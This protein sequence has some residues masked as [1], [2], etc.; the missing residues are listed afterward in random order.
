MSLIN[1][2]LKRAGRVQKETPPPTEPPTA[3]LT[4]VEP[5]PPAPS[6]GRGGPVRAILLMLALASLAG[7]SFF[8]W[9]FF[10]AGSAPPLAAAAKPGP[11][12][13]ADT[14]PQPT[15]ADK[16]ATNLVAEPATPPVGPAATQTV[17]A[18][19]PPPSP[20]AQLEPAGA[21]K[22]PAE[23]ATT[24]VAQAVAPSPAPPPAQATPS[25]PPPA[26]A[27]AQPAAPV[28]EPP[29]VAVAWPPLKLQA[30]IFRVK[31]PKVRINGTNLS[32][33]AEVDGVYVEEIR[34]DAVTVKLGGETKVLFLKR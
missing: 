14:Q 28:A 31:D 6:T 9:R 11:V 5:P 30:I 1:E 7:G 32:V 20:S 25:E 29:P 21:A 33:G 16:A 4:P 27:Q 15:P 8:V 26:P 19:A 18:A 22:A 3:G 23:A 34:S 13:K 10:Q 12:A 24:T 2:A 17:A